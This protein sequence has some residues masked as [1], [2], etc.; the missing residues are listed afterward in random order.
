MTTINDISFKTKA[1]R[2]RFEKAIEAL[3]AFGEVEITPQNPFDSVYRARVTLPYRGPMLTCPSA[4]DL[5]ISVTVR[6]RKTD[7][8]SVN[9]G[10]LPNEASYRAAQRRMREMNQPGFVRKEPY[11]S[12]R[13]EVP[14]SELGQAVVHCL[15]HVTTDRG[16][17]M[18]AP[19]DL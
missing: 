11:W 8:E 19:C 17:W 16:H 10:H 4:G 18:P 9:V 5:V 1:A 2:S 7:I 13:Y 6:D 14:V 15:V 3:S 12:T